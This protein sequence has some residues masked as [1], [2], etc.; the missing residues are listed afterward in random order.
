MEGGSTILK[1]IT[2]GI[3]AFILLGMIALLIRTFTL[4]LGFLSLPLADVLQR[5][6]PTRQWL[7]R[8]ARRRSPK[9]DEQAR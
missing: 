9:A 3:L 5:W 6:R 1:F 2:Y 8:R 4:A 7:E